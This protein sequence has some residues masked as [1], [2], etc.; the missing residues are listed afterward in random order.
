MRVI[1]A[2]LTYNR[3]DLAESIVRQMGGDVVI[4]DN[5]SQ[6]ALPRYNNR[7]ID[8]T[9]N[10]FWTG[11]WNWAMTAFK[12]EDYV[13]MLNDDVQ[14][15]SPEKA[16]AL[17]TLAR[18][19]GV[20]MISPSFNSPHPHMQ[21]QSGEANHFAN[22]Q[23]WV[24]VRFVPWIDMTAPMMSVDWYHRVGGLD[25]RFVGYGADLDLCK[26]IAQAGGRFAVCDHIQIHHIGSE[27]AMSEGVSAH[28]DVGL[29]NQRLREKWG[30]ND[31]TEMF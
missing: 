26:R 21:P 18:D 19:L 15:V 16:T 12:D 2:S 24:S 8:C 31:W 22:G 23:G 20:S 7:Q 11:G 6:P 13:W 14:Q 27:T 17:A 1:T 5:G 3:P 29:M 28:V 4:I 25:T 30:V 9:E 10:R